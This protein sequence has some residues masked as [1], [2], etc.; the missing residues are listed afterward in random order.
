[1]EILPSGTVTGMWLRAPDGTVIA[2]VTAGAAGFYDSALAHFYSRLTDT[3]AEKPIYAI[4]N[5]LGNLFGN[6][7]YIPGSPVADHL[8]NFGAGVGQMLGGGGNDTL[9]SFGYDKVIMAGEAGNDLIRVGEGTFEV[10]G[11]NADGSGGTGETNT[12]EIRGS[13]HGSSNATI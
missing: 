5:A 6:A 11:A 4:L 7:D 2:Q 13:A 12:L 3:S 8:T 9:I 1:G 10:H